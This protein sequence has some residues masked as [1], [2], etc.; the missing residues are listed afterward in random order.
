[1][2]DP[3]PIRFTPALIIVD[4][5]EDFCPPNGSLAVPDARS[6]TPTINR[7]LSLPFAVRIA[8]KDWHPANHISFA[9]NHPAPNNMPF[10]NEITI[11]NP[12]NPSETQ[13]TRLWPNHC[14]QHTSGAALVPELDIDRVQH[15]VE[16]G[17]DP[18]VEMYSAFADP[19]LSPTVSRSG[20]ADMLR[21]AEVTHVFIVGLALDYCVKFTALDAAKEGFATY[22]IAE[23][24]KPVD[25][26]A[27]ADVGNTFAGNGVGL[28][29][30]DSTMVDKV[31]NLGGK[32][33]VLRDAEVP[34]VAL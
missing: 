16:K 20:L 2:T 26:G 27:W 12:H 11:T 28:I 24:T 5:Q 18:R 33:A 29:R 4:F 32:G 10:T 30:E 25:P 17:Q 31:R 15:V 19:F 13:T 7:L 21:A 22:V 3:I 34:T 8:T 14:V 9:S 23:G 6:I 1:M